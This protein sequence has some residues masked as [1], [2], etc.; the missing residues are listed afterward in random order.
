MSELFVAVGLRAKAGKE[1]ELRRDLTAV[2]EPSRKEEGCL[3]YELF[4]DSNTS[5]L[6]VFFEHWASAEAQQKHHTQGP[7]I[8]HFQANGI[9]NVERNEFVHMLRRLA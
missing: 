3:R 8:Q 6:F 4:E 2:V 1:E 9:A 7:H 5:G